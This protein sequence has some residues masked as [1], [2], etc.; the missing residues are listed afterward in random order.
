M[1]IRILNEKD[2]LLINDDGEYITLTPTELKL[3]KELIINRGTVLSVEAMYYVMTDHPSLDK[4]QYSHYVRTVV[5]RLRNKGVP[6]RN[7]R[8]YGYYIK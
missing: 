3:T 1:T 7:R 6:I 4:Q 5:W 2:R 8:G